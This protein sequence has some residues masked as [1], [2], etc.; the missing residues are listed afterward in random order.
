MPMPMPMPILMLSVL[1]MALTLVPIASTSAMDAPVTKQAAE[2]TRLQIAKAARYEASDAKKA[3]EAAYLSRSN[4]VSAKEIARRQSLHNP[5]ND[6][7]DM[8]IRLERTPCFGPCPIYS[9]TV[10]G[11]RTVTFVSHDP[12]ARVVDDPESHIGINWSCCDLVRKKILSLRDF[13]RLETQIEGMDFFKLNENYSAQVT[14]L[15]S[16]RITV[17]APWGVHSVRRYAVPCQTEYRK[18]MATKDDP[19][20]NSYLRNIPP[21]PDSLCKLESMIDRLTG[22]DKWGEETKLRWNGK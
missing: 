8:V 12:A 6:Q 18:I 1:T 14:D 10:L 11:D 13:N 7:H 4:S 15:P 2:A 22:A 5:V 19:G 20:I 21:P 16:V 17:I 9:V 3:A